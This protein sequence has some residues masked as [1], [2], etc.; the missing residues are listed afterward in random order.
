MYLKYFKTI[1]LSIVSS[2]CLFAQTEPVE[3]KRSEDRIVIERRVYYI[4][5]VEPGQTL[6]SISRA[7]NVPQKEII[8][9]NPTLYVLELQ[10][11]QTLKIPFR[12]EA[13]EEE[14][15]ADEPEGEF[16]FHTVEPGQTLFFLSRTYNVDMDDIVSLNPGVEEGLQ[17]GQVVRIPAR[18]V[19][20]SREG[21]PAEDDN[22]IYHKVE[23][24]ET[25][26]S[27]SRRYDVPVRAIR[28]ANSRLIWG[29]KYGEFI[30]IP[31]D[32]DDHDYEFEIAE[33]PFD[34]VAEPLQ[35]DIDEEEILFEAGCMQFDYREY[36]RPFNVSVLLPLFIERNY[37]VEVPDT[38]D[39]E[40]IAALYPDYVRSTSELHHSTIPF[41]EFYEGARLAV[42]SL[43]RAGLSVNLNVYDTERSTEKVREIIRKREFRSSDLIIGPVYPE[44]MSIVADWA[45]QNRVNIVSPLTPRSEFL[46]GNPYIFQ[47]TPPASVEL[48]Q[49]SIFISNFPCS[50]FV[51]IHKNDPFER[52]LVEA[53]KAN[54]FKHF[55]YNSTFDDVVFKEVIF[56][57]QTVNIEQSLVEGEKNVVIVPSTNQAF[58]SDVL[59]RLNVLSRNYDITIFGMNDWQRFANIEVEYFHNLELHFASPFFVDYENEN[60][61]NFLRRFRE[62]YKTEPSQ[63]GFLGYDIMFY[64]LGAMHKYGPDFRDCLPVIHTELLQTEF[65]FRKSDYRNGFENNGISIVKYEKDMNITRLGLNART[66]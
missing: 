48:E 51:L 32:P 58:V 39:Q 10:A 16:I 59:I 53:F 2:F 1:F 61:R 6:Y 57:D 23:R 52:D 12:P 35:P 29:L 66:P 54:I 49:A 62:K 47:V 55:S 13:E 43:V 42:D 4:H 24:G 40:Q 26:F 37:P 17:I 60:V 44:N 11:G 28:R 64:F 38:L 19:Y 56:E 3:V 20:I 50:N 25:L 63:Y 45:R 31:K 41:L 22:Y 8:L 18:R 36:D 46:Y 5:V 9:E 14:V 21:F 15:V 7:Y 27:L 34:I 30:R 65:L 33:V